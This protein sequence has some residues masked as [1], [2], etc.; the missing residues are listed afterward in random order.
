[1]ARTLNLD[2]ALEVAEK[3]SAEAS[4]AKATDTRQANRKAAAG[5]WEDFDLEK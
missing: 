4:E 2:T 5:T 1:M 3:A